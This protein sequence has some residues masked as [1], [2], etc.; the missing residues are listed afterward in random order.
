MMLLLP[1]QYPCTTELLS[2][3]CW[4]IYYCSCTIINSIT[5]SILSKTILS[6]QSSPVQAICLLILLSCWSV[7]DTCIQLLKLTTT[8]SGV[9]E[10]RVALQPNIQYLK[11]P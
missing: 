9:K 10:W 1:Y 4:S 5:S 2:P 3:F 7:T 11:D 8:L 6:L